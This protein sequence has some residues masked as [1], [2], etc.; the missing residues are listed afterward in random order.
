MLPQ[1]NPKVLFKEQSDGAVL[2]SMDD[3]VYFGL[4]EVGAEIWALLPPVSN[5]VEEICDAIAM[6]YPEVDPAVIHAD[7][8][9]L[10]A[11]LVSHGLLIPREAAHPNAHDAPNSSAAGD[12]GSSRLG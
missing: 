6:R 12:T 9:Q 7:V 8:T 2:F 3:E 5:T 11:D 10:I 4:N 1:P